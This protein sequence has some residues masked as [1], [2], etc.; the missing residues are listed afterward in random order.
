MTNQA[1]EMKSSQQDSGKSEAKMATERRSTQKKG[2]VYVPFTDSDRKHLLASFAQNPSPTVPDRMKLS[3]M[4]GKPQD[5]ISRWFT[6]RRFYLKR[7]NTENVSTELKSSPKTNPEMVEQLTK[8]RKIELP[9][10]PETAHPEKFTLEDAVKVK[11][12][13]DTCS[14]FT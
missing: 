2:K 10:K 14:S 5:Q 1:A 9:N 3:V 6:N 8:K 12:S 11:I 13:R 7:H 4:L